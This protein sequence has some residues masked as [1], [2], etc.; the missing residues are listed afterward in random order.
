[1]LRRESFENANLRE[2]VDVKATAVQLDVQ[3]LVT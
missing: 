3:P 1:M 2:L